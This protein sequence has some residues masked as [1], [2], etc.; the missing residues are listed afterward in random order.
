MSYI[1][2]NHAKDRINQRKIPESYISAT[3]NNP[4]TTNHGKQ[5]GTMEYTKRF[6]KYK[7]T[8]IAK[9]NERYEWIILSTWMDPPMTGTED[10]KKRQEYKA[11]QKSSGWGKVWIMIKKSF[12]L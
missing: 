11:Y 5:S 3:F 10:E 8:L 4:D 9:Q 12:G 2:T 7:V 6:D 1:L